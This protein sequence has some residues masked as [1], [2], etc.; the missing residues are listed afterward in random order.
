MSLKSLL[1]EEKHHC[2][3]L[4]P[5]Y[6]PIWL[7]MAWCPDMLF[8]YMIRAGLLPEEP[9]V[10]F[11]AKRGKEIV[12]RLDGKFRSDNEGH[13]VAVTLRGRVLAVSDTLETLNKKLANMKIRENYHIERLGHD[14]ITEI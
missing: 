12:S 11:R 2:P 10:E 1:I 7:P 14:V 3:G 13:Y 8:P 5:Y 9:S 4:F 6:Y